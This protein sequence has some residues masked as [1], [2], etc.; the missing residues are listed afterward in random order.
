LAR[1][2]QDN[3]QLRK[4]L[5]GQ[6]SVCKERMPTPGSC[7][8]E[9][10]N[11]AVQAAQL[12]LWDWNIPQK[13][14]FL[15]P[16]WGHITGGEYRARTQPIEALLAQIHPDD[17]AQVQKQINALLRG[18]TQRYA[19]EYR[20]H[21]PRG[22]V[23]IESVGLP[24]E[25]D[26]QG[27]ISRVVGTLAD[28]TARKQVQEQLTVAQARA[29]QASQAKSEFLAN[30]SHEVRTPLNAI[31]GL[32][33]LLH[34]T[35]VSPQ[36]KEYLELMDGSATALL[37]LLNDILDLSKI[38]AGKLVFEQVRFD[39]L[40]WIEQA[41]SPFEAQAQEKGLYVYVDADPALPPYLVGDPGRLRQVLSNL[42]SNAVKF[43]QQ[44]SVQLKVWLDSEQSDL[45]PGRLRVLFEVRDTGIG[46]A[47][48]KQAAIF[49]AFT[50]ADPSTTRQYGGTGLG[51]TIC[52]RLVDMMGG[53]IRVAS[54]LGKGSAF[55]FSAVFSE[56]PECPTEITMPIALEAR[57]LAGLTVLLAED[58][59]VNQL[60]T[61]KLLEEMGCRVAVANNGQEAVSR[62]QRGGIDLIL[63]D[64]Q[65]PVLSGEA[66]TAQ[67]RTHERPLGRHTPII[68]ITAHALAGDRER[69]LAA[70]MDAYV[71]KPISPDMLAQAMHDALAN[72]NPMPPSLLPDMDFH[73]TRP[74]H[75]S[76]EPLPLA[77][78]VSTAP[79]PA[80]EQP[81]GFDIHR[82]LA[83]LGGDRAALVEVTQAMRTDLAQRLAQLRVAASTQN[84]DL[85]CRQAHALKG[86][87]STL[88][89]SRGAALAGGLELAA[90]K[91]EWGLFTR[92]LQ[93]LEQESVQIDKTLAQVS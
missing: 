17:V 61:R 71:S 11:L 13:S 15:S 53:Q 5:A 47:Q 64:I 86:S 45:P 28:I 56:A 37:A 22:W 42:F 34:R 84:A 82:L 32:T 81:N 68:A 30:M 48:E 93:L 19:A 12:A 70:G 51:L 40:S 6:P 25:R 91:A 24:Q 36:Q 44:G 29:E 8:L 62:W 9:Q 49:E 77:S 63:M 85:A 27:R 10:L 76:S 26:A 60:I 54:V 7:E 21:S 18:Q 92:A 41:V 90:R 74:P 58:H 20:V 14:V 65:M 52:G 50:Q 38:E 78:T 59:P 89:L 4:Q 16:Y 75:L 1:L 33:R 69:Y 87:L 23:W 3:A 88:T 46:I 80:P 2:Q 66:A 39:L 55:R 31:M 43:T 72:G 35:P 73:A 79:Q 83:Q 57:T 67:I